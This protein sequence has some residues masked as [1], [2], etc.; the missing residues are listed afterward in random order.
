MLFKISGVALVYSWNNQLTF[1]LMEYATLN[2]SAIWLMLL[3]TQ[4]LLVCDLQLLLDHQL[5]TRNSALRYTDGQKSN[6]LFLKGMP[7]FLY[8]DLEKKSGTA[9][10]LL[11]PP[12]LSKMDLLNLPGTGVLS[13]FNQLRTALTGPVLCW[14]IVNYCRYIGLYK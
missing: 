8:R 14:W 4:W 1:I 5:L 2:L 12:T 11:P 13:W 9:P 10:A 6:P 3:I 7:A